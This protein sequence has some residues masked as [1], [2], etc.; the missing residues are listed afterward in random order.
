M[1]GHGRAGRLLAG[2]TIVAL[3]GGCAGSVPSATPS[4]APSA[5]APSAPATSTQQPAPTPPASP[6]AIV[7]TPTIELTGFSMRG[8]VVGLPSALYFAVDAA[9]NLYLPDG[10][11]GSALVKI[12]LTAASSPTGR[13]WRSS[14]GS[15]TRSSASP[16][17]RAPGMSS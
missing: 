2:V 13:G 11:E 4:S 15:P 5:G 7:P 17:S 10:T 9:G 6:T 1:G 8:F 3:L 12:A 16:S 14:R